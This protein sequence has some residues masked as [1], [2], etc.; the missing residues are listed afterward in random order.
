MIDSLDI[1]D[2]PAWRHD[3]FV[4]DNLSSGFGPS[5]KPTPSSRIASPDRPAV[6][7]ALGMR[8]IWENWLTEVA[9]RH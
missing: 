5:A 4:V 2:L 1:F 8:G 7:F 3:A 9:E 6:G